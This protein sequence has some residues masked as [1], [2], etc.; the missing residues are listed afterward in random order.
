MSRRPPTRQC[1]RCG[2]WNQS[3]SKICGACYT[4]LAQPRFRMTPDR[5]KFLHVL[6]LRQK[7]LDREDYEARLQRVGVTTC[8]DL[9]L[10]QYRELVD[11]LR[12]LPDAA[13]A[14]RTRQ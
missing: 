8:K 3:S 7:G 12:K 14:G 11:G 9:T 1:Q 2:T 13:R 6:A 5:V 4:P 10:R